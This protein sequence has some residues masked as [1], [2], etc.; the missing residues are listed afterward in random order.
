MWRSVRS[1]PGV[2]VG[3]LRGWSRTEDHGGPRQSAVGAVAGE[4]CLLLSGK[5]E[6][7]MRRDRAAGRWSHCLDAALQ[8]LLLVC[9]RQVITFE[10]TAYR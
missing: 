2:A 5:A 10:W 3:L 7:A 8:S 6:F 4:G 1:A 9:Q